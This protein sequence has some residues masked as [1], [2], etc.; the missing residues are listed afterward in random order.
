[1]TLLR[2]LLLRVLAYLALALWSTWPVAVRPLT[3]VPG[4]ERTDLWNSLWSLWFF[5]HQLWDG[6]YSAHT[7]L[8]SFPTGGTLLVADPLNALLAAPLIPLLGTA[9][10]YTL[11]VWLQLTLA[12]LVAHAFAEELVRR[13]GAGWIAGVG[14]ATAPVLLS[15][16]HNGTSESFAGGWVALAAWTSWRA[17][18]LGGAR[19]VALAVMA[20]LVASLASWYAAVTAFLFAGALL[21]LP[22]LG[23]WLDGLG[24]RIAV[25]GLGVLAAAPFAWLVKAASTAPDNLVA[26]KSDRE[27]MGIRRSTGVADILGFFA[28]GDF[29]SP[30]FRLLSRYGEAFFH[31][32]YLGY[33]LLVGAALSL[34][35]DRGRERRFLWLAGGLGAILAM[36]PVLV[37]DASA[38]VIFDDRV[39]PLPYLLLEYLPGFDGLSLLYR[40]AM[41]TSLALALLAAAGLAGRARWWLAPPAIL[42]EGWLLCPLGGLPDAVDASVSPAVAAIAEGPDGAVMNFPVVGGRN[43]LYEQTVHQRPVTDTLNFPNNLTSRRVWDR[44][45]AGA[46]G[47][48]GGAS[49]AGG[50]RGEAVGGTLPRRPRGRGGETGHA[51][52]RGAGHRCQLRPL[53]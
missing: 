37:R 7:T 53:R 48:R 43:Y 20:L 22:P 31:C 14:F 33:V 42:L 47:R 39:V 26:I 28:P 34:W 8:I 49:G 25:V 21:V 12:G 27:V 1:M 29:R 23:R 38:W 35:Q 2:S 11:L 18:R 10:T 50:A 46:G 16:V 36:G 3:T 52:H 4:A 44:G 6:G 45:A 32:H 24:R 9:P 13:T 41:A 19:R 5:Q 30:D 51:Q 15:G 40:L 17:A